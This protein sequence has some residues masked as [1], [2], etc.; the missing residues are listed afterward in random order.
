MWIEGFW[1]SAVVLRCRFQQSELGGVHRLL[2]AGG[3]PLMPRPALLGHLLPFASDLKALALP[4]CFVS[5]SEL[6]ALTP[7]PSTMPRPSYAVPSSPW[8]AAIVERVL[9]SLYVQP[10]ARGMW[11]RKV[12]Y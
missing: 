7:G 11:L 10:S 12:L 5:V 4:W 3:S 8:L 9:R 6:P 2:P 1:C